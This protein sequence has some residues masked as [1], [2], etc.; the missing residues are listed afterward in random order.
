M[1][2]GAA[3]DTLLFIDHTDAILV[4]CDRIYRT[5][6]FAWALQMGD[7]IIRTGLCALA[8]L[9]ALIWI[10]IG[11]VVTHGD[12]SKI[13]GILAGLSH[14]LAAVICD[15]IGRN[16]T[17]LAGCVNDLN[18]IGTVSSCRALAFCQ[19]D[20]LLDDL[21][22]LVNTAAVAGLRARN[23]II[24]DLIPFFLQI[25]LPCSFR[26]LIEHVMFQAQDRCIICYH[27]SFPPFIIPDACSKRPDSKYI[28]WKAQRAHCQLNNR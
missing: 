12:G 9:L 19:T 21:T 17:L 23:H 14:T 5:D 25:S 15:N 10:N 20:S 13:T 16:G 26:D 24:W 2:T 7:R 18:H 22:L 28:S 1:D 4:I 3:L 11:M 8:A 6:L 27:F